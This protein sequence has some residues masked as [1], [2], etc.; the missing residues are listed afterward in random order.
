MSCTVYICVH[1]FKWPN[2]IIMTNLRVVE[3][4]TVLVVTEIIRHGLN[5]KITN[6]LDNKGRGQF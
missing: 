1:L 3:I 4:V 5:E 6:L 2:H